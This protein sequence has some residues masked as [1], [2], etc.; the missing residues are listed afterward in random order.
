[1]EIKINEENN[2]VKVLYNN[3]GIKREKD[4][5]FDDLISSLIASK[6]KDKKE[7]FKSISSPISNKIDGVRLVQTK[8][9]EK[10]AYIYVLRRDKLFAP[11]MLFDRNYDNVGYP[12]LL[13]GLKVVNNKVTNGYL[14]SVKDEIITD[15]TM[16]YEYPYTNVS[17]I[18]G[19]ICLGDNSFPEDIEN[20]P[21]YLYKIPHMIVSMP[22]SLHSF[23]EEN[24][25]KRLSMEQLLIKFHNKEFDDSILV[26]KNSYG[27]WFELL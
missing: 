5:S 6:N 17:G 25:S 2:T 21:Y 8:Q 3:N 10:N 14:V 19:S 7:K 15:T 12:A 13:F 18:R 16:L 23:K 24:N 9:I 27:K 1:M 26:P 11:T 22:N 4:V 20:D